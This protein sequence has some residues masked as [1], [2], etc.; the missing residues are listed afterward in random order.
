MELITS[1]LFLLP[2][3]IQCSLTL[4]SAKRAVL[5]HKLLC[6]LMP[7]PYF[8]LKNLAFIEAEGWRWACYGSVCIHHFLCI[9]SQWG[10]D[11]CSVKCLFSS[12]RYYCTWQQWDESCL[13][14]PHS[15]TLAVT[16]MLEMP[17]ASYPSLAN[18]LLVARSYHR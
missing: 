1:V 16:G 9:L 11:P 13:L 2:F 4:L 7:H 6:K 10:A 14:V 12:R 8:F 15:R 3:P 5:Q 18:L 17:M